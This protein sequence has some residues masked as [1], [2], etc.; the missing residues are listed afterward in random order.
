M[1]ERALAICERAYGRDHPDTRYTLMDLGKVWHALGDA[2]KARDYIGEA[3]AICERHYG[4][5]H[6]ETIKCKD[7]LAELS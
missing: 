1:Q 4:A 6:S 5:N 3:L 7:A 2:T